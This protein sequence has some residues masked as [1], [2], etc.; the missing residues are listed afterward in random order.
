MNFYKKHLQN[1]K[2]TVKRV[3]FSFNFGWYPIHLDIVC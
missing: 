3:Y 2:Y 1:L